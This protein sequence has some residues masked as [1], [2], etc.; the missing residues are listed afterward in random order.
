MSQTN[1]VTLET[2]KDF[3]NMTTTSE[4]DDL[5][6]PNERLEELFRF[7]AKIVGK[8]F[9]KEKL[10]DGELVYLVREPNNPWDSN[11]IKVESINHQQVGHISAG[12]SYPNIADCLSPIMDFKLDPTEPNKVG[13]L[14][15]AV[16]VQGNFSKYTSLCLITLVG[17][18]DHHDAISQHL[19]THRVPH[20]DLRKNTCLMGYIDIEKPDQ[21]ISSQE[22]SQSIVSDPKQSIS[23]VTEQQKISSKEIFDSMNAVWDEIDRDVESLTL[24]NTDIS[25]LEKCLKSELMNHQKVG[26]AWMLK[27]E[28]GRVQDELP[29]FYCSLP[30]GKFSH[31]LTRHHY[32]QRPNNICGGVLAD[33]MGLGKTLQLLSLILAHPPPGRAFQPQTTRSDSASESSTAF[34]TPDKENLELAASNQQM[35]SQNIKAEKETLE[36]NVSNQQELALKTRA[37]LKAM[38]L[39]RGLPVS[40]NKDTLISRIIN[41]LPLP[42]PEQTPSMHTPTLI[43]CPLSVISAW[44]EQL[45]LHV[46]EGTLKLLTYHS[47]SRNQFTD[48]E[49][50]AADIVLT[51]YD[52]LAAEFQG[53][54]SDDVLV[55]LLKKQKVTASLWNIN[56]WRIILDEAHII[57]NTTTRRFKAVLNLKATFRWVVT[58]TAIVNSVAD[59]DAPCRFLRLEPFCSDVAL[60]QRYLVRPVKSGNTEAIAMVRA[61]LKTISLRREKDAVQEL[62]L[63]TKNEIKVVI[64]LS[65]KEQDAYSALHEAIKNYQSLAEDTSGATGILRNTQT[66]LSLITRLRQAC[67][68]LSLVPTSD[69]V[70]I[71]SKASNGK[72]NIELLT[73]EEKTM[74]LSKLNEL[75]LAAGVGASPS[76]TEES[77]NVDVEDCMVCFEPLQES[78]VI[79]FRGCKHTFCQECVDKFFTASC[80]KMSPIPQDAKVSCPMCRSLVS[81]QDCL[82]FTALHSSLASNEANISDKRTTSDEKKKTPS[83]KTLA[84][85]KEL[86]H[87]QSRGEK[88][89]IFSSFTSY[90]DIISDALAD[91]GYN[92][93]RIDGKVPQKRRSSEIDRFSR[94]ET[95]TVM[96]CS[97]KACGVGITLTRANNVFLTDLWWA[98][99]VDM[100]AIDRCHRIGQTKAV[101]VLRF[102]VRDSI[103]EKI[104]EL[105]LKKI[106]LAKEVA[107]P[108]TSKELKELRAKDIAALLN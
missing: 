38:C 44:Q 34:V 35:L 37:Q 95:V 101:N 21:E 50:T 103:D 54:N 61:L 33:S 102:L 31:A 46:Y 59:L 98:P 87:V 30:G 77:A 17:A 78:N 82:S 68:D 7:Q 88:T 27:R 16:S 23:V 19:K 85:L 8:R 76:D 108:L 99:S 57:R 106:A 48:E 51:T 45:S 3:E 11:A 104:F 18:P 60:F 81:R 58:G 13:A 25:I 40:G 24:D 105:Q 75:F 80:Q 12:S 2:R 55:P 62:Q 10:N 14:A 39:E 86:Q 56:W 36:L 93:C 70:N 84:I 63:P 43:V 1:L 100:Q 15:E 42:S 22:S 66:M 6:D 67:L 71:L 64:D 52:V 41:K 53:V 90:L 65:E 26:V 20:R 4:S 49:L 83:S 89:V 72:T 96:L 79:I 29:P 107:K 91:A 9:Y 28:S 69:L 97:L 73:F 5:N 74:M 94:D 32:N 92:C 47:Q